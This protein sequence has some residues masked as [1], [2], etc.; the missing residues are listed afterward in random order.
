MSKPCSSR[1]QISRSKKASQLR[2]RAKLSSVM[3][4]RL[5]F[6]AQ[7]LRITASRSSADLNRL[8][9]PCTLMMVQKEHW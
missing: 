3:K 1:S 7:F 8:L 9:R 4:K 6:C 5:M 2:L